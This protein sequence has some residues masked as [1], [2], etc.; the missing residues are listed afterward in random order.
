MGCFILF[1]TILTLLCEYHAEVQN[2]SA[3]LFFPTVPSFV[4]KQPTKLMSHKN[5]HKKR[6]N[7]LCIFNDVL[8]KEGK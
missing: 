3:A 2:G 6:G 8:D 4:C 7:T 1:Y 5:T